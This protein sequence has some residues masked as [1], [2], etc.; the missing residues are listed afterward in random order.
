MEIYLVRH[1]ETEWNKEERLQGWSDSPLS[2]YGRQTAKKLAHKLESIPFN[3]AYS[4]DLGRARES[5]EILVGQRHIPIEYTKDLRELCLGPWEG[6]TFQ[7]VKIQEPEKMKRYFESP[8]LH[9][10]EGYE[11]Y[12]DL[13]KRIKSFL[14]RL[15]E[16]SYQ[17]VLIV[18]HGVSVQ[19]IINEIL[20]IDLKDF[21]SRPLVRGMDITKI[22]LDNSVFKLISRAKQIEGKSY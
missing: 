6:K 9:E 7:E 10:L 17:H 2:D 18:G 16:S 11:N 13:Q 15:K 22:Q 21:W 20:Q 4:S 1:A 12:H 8:Q 5:V 3:M 19:C 14:G